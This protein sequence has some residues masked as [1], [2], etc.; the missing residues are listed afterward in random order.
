MTNKELIVKIK[1]EIE[2]RLKDYWEISFHDTN[3]YNKDTNVKEL[4]ELLSFLSTLESENPVPNDLEEASMS[5][6]HKIADESDVDDN[7][8]PII[9]IFEVSTAFEAGAKW[10]REQMMNEAEE[11]ELYWDGYFLAIDLNMTAL[12]YSEGD[13]V[14]VIIVKED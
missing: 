6:Q 4:K 7:G 10:D 8:Y 11:C 2:R 14:R 9:G 13:K 1:A 3:S 12:G 5:Y